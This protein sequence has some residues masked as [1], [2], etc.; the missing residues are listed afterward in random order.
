MLNQFKDFCSGVTGTCGPF[1]GT[2]EETSESCET[3]YLTFKTSGSV[4]NTRIQ[5]STS[6]SS[7]GANPMDTVEAV[8][9]LK[10]SLAI[11]V[12]P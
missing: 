8:L 10:G 9:V 11:H 3:S 12:H 1:I 7:S 5:C 4:N 2:N 6:S